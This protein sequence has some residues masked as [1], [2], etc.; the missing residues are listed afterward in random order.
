[1]ATYNAASA[2][3]KI[4]PN[5]AGFAAKLR[6]DLRRVDVEHKVKLTPDMSGFAQELRTKLSAVRATIPVG[7]DVDT[8]R[9]RAQLEAVR[10]TVPANVDVDVAAV[11]AQLAAIPAVQLNADVK[12]NRSQVRDALRAWLSNAPAVKVT[13]RFD[14]SQLRSALAAVSLPDVRLNTDIRVDRAAIRA[15]LAAMTGLRVPVSVKVDVAQI[16]QQLATVPATDLNAKLKLNAAQ[17]RTELERFSPTVKAKL[18]IDASGAMA[19]L[20][21]VH[22]VMQAWLTANPLTIRV[23]VDNSTI[24]RMIGSFNRLSNAGESSSRSTNKIGSSIGRLS[25]GVGKMS[26]VGAA[27]AGIGGAAGLAAG[28]VGGLG[29]G[30]AGLAGLAMPGIAAITVGL[31]GIG[32]AFSAFGKDAGGGGAAADNSAQIANAE[33]AIQMAL[34]ASKDAQEDLTRARKD[35]RREIEDLNMSLKESALDER[36]AAI[37]VAD[38]RDELAKTKKDPKSS[39]RDEQ[40]AQLRLEQA[41]LRQQEASK[42][43]ARLAQDTYDANK[44]GIEGSDQ[45]VDAKRAIADADY[46][47]AQARKSLEDA[48]KGTGGGGGKDPLAEALAKLSPNAREFVETVHG[49][50]DAW[51]EVKKSTQDALF[52]GA[53]AS[54]TSLASATLPM[55]KTGMTGVATSMNGAAKDL[56]AMLAQEGNVAKMGTAFAGSAVFIDQAKVGLMGMTQGMID[57]GAAAAPAAAS[58]GQGFGAIFGE[59]GKSISDLANSGALTQLFESLGGFLSG[60]LGPA[61]G[62]LVT[63]LTNL[64]NAVLPALTP[65]FAALGEAFVTISEPLG[66][67]GAAFADALVPLLPIVAQFVGVLAEGLTPIIPILGEIIGA[68]GQA[69]MPLIPPLSTAIQLVGDTIAQLLPIAGPVFEQLAGLLASVLDAVLPILPPLFELASAILTPLIGILSQ[70]VAALAPFINQLVAMLAPIIAQ[71]AP[72]LAEV[73][74]ILGEALTQAISM[75]MP[76]LM[77]L[78]EAVLGLFKSLLPLIPP[79]IQIAAN[80]LPLMFVSFQV[81]IPIVTKLVEW[82]TVLVEG[83]LKIAIPWIE[84]VAEWAGKLGEMFTNIGPKIAEFAQGLKDKIG[85]AKDWVVEKFTAVV[86]FVKGLPG[87]IAESTK[88]MWDGIKNAFK[89]ALNWLIQKWNNFSLGFD[90]KIPVINKQIK[91]SIDTPDIPLFADGGRISGPGT[92]RSDSILARLSNGEFVVN[93]RD[94]ARNLPLLNQINNGGTPTP[95]MLPAFADGGLVAGAALP[96]WGSEGGLQPIAVMVRRLIHSLWSQISDIG[97]YRSSDPFPDHPSGQAL[98]IMISD[99]GLGDSVKAWLMDNR[100]LFHLNYTIWQQLYEPASGGGNLMED[101]GDPTQNHM[102]HIHSLFGEIGAPPAVDPDIVPSGLKLPSG[103]QTEEKTPDPSTVTINSDPTTTDTTVASDE[104]ASDTIAPSQILRKFGETSGGIV[105]DSLLKIFDPGGDLG[106]QSVLSAAD[107]YVAFGRAVAGQTDDKTSSKDN[108]APGGDAAPSPQIPDVPDPAEQ[109]KGRPEIVWS[110]S[111]GAEQWR[112]LAEWAIEHVN[113]TLKGAGQT[114]AMVE[115]IGDESGGDPKA[116]NDYDINAQNGDP[117]GGL[118]Q[119]I[120]QTFDAFRDQTLPNDKFDPAANLVAALNYYADRY[121]DDLTSRWGH[122]KGGYALG[123]YVSGPGTGTSDSIRARISNGEFV[124]NAA[125]T[126]RNLPMLQAINSGGDVAPTDGRSWRPGVQ[127]NNNVTVSSE[128]SQMREMRRQDEW[129]MAMYGGAK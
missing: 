97:G 54:F 28:A 104:V 105:A 51:D 68:L 99:V 106:P 29:V 85:E 129:A 114:T 79:L 73:G 38:A 109:V 116:V 9:L 27:V 108:A 34:R 41:I 53:A 95:G 111:G 49:M 126:S 63:A 112:P 42:R 90:F 10:V 20:R 17:I 89:D 80:L 19:E 88:N 120:G 110:A 4:G 11:R 44:K 36:E 43:G 117:S 30:L 65:A 107:R 21:R 16:R 78:I 96:A 103:M 101:R 48:M 15:R 12:V 67:L 23:R 81:L 61:L 92:G 115:Q 58:L 22:S 8:A 14:Q 50:S 39:A 5:L 82:L 84:K 1:M 45:V 18:D 76:I 93:A 62:D 98:D 87:K 2:S 57:A 102:D 55:L 33:R 75:L 40:K 83:A 123:G 125:A 66:T 59:I 70:V 64:G 37:A 72:I 35:A 52:D 25:G 3:V 86:D 31:R 119:V 100:G 6:Q 128:R 13:G 74:S 24:E 127:I 91:F 56:S 7:L 124:V 32:D 118:L 94:T 121:G 47:L 26:M 69:L 60:G 46:D 113:K 122:G 77:P 71:I